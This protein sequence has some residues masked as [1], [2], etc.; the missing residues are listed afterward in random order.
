MNFKLKDKMLLFFSVLILIFG[1]LIFIFVKD[2]ID[3]L[4][5]YTIERQLKSIVDLEYELFSNE[6]KGEWKLENGNLYKGDIL[7]SESK[8]AVDAISGASRYSIS[9]LSKNKIV[10]TSIKDIDS[11][12]T[13][14]DLGNIEGNKIK[15]ENVEG[16]YYE[17]IYKPILDNNKNLIG[18]F[19]VW[20]LKDDIINMKNNILKKILII[21][22]IMILAGIV[23]IFLF[24]IGIN[25]SLSKITTNISKMAQGNYL[26][27]IKDKYLKRKDE[28]GLLSRAIK[29]MAEKQSEVL[30]NIQVD[31]KKMDESSKHL[32]TAVEDINS[33]VEEI[34]SST[35]EI[36]SFME[37]VDAS[38]MA[39]SSTINE[40]ASNIKNIDNDIK[41]GSKTI[42]QIKNRAEY[43]QQISLKSQ[44]DTKKIYMQ[45]QEKILEAIKKGEVVKEINNMAQFISN[46]AHRTNLLALNASIEAARSGEEGKGFTVVAEEIRN[47]A[48]QSAQTVTNINDVI[49]EV[50]EAFENFS[51]NAKDILDFINEKVIKDYDMMKNISIRYQMDSTLMDEVIQKFANNIEK[52]NNSMEKINKKV[53]EITQAINSVTANTQTISAGLN[54]SASSI[55]E[56]SN[57]AQENSKL[58]ENLASILKQFKVN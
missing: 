28:M 36:A 16:I 56:I 37:E 49:E 52:T 33:R 58:G 42:N 10:V 12:F 31:A 18:Y 11:T 13:I 30:K 57:V 55:E 32:Y 5:N 24:G 47:L 3:E 48:E 29:D 22:I 50:Y 7:L 23:I 51:D 35:E 46:I 45:K 14:S 21:S 15:E 9:I 19:S 41:K 39:V 17:V 44:E 6:F 34:N 38:S 4:N 27:E 25:R 20:A 26:V 8:E 2:G 54:E 40:V 53:E 43:V 1:I